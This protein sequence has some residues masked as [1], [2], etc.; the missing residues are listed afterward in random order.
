MLGSFPR[1]IPHSSRRSVAPHSTAPA[2]EPPE[3]KMVSL[4]SPVVKAIT[5]PV[6]KLGFT[7]LSAVN[8][9]PDSAAIVLLF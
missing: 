6:V 3:S 1:M 7:L 2:T 9:R 8:P 4:F 5:P